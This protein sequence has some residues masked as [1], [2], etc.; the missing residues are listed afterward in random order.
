V[1]TYVFSCACGWQGEQRTTFDQNS[2][3]CPSCAATA[4]KESVYRVSF[5]GFARTPSEERDWSRD[6]KNYREA[7]AEIDYKKERLEEGLG[8][9]LPDPPL[10][11]VAQARAKDLL[12]KGV[13]DANDL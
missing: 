1:P 3:S 4:H 6:Y 13:K 8:Q 5:G 9:R 2:V 7:S 10:F 12:R 11:Q